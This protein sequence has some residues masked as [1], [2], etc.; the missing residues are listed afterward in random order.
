MIETW[1]YCLMRLAAAPMLADDEKFMRLGERFRDAEPMLG[2]VQGL[3]L[4]MVLAVLAVGIW[5]LQRTI[6]AGRDRVLDSPGKLFGQLCRRHGLTSGQR[7]LLHGLAARHELAQPAWL[8]VDCGLLDAA[9]AGDE[10]LA[11]RERLVRLRRQ[12]FGEAHG[13]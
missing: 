8:F 1:Q 5:F 10:D 2:W 11:T 4:L 13:R 12:L 3:L 9:A 6:G 7:R